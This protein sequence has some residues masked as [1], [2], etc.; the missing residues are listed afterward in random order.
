M[1]TFDMDRFHM[2]RLEPGSDLLGGIEDFLNDRGIRSGYFW[3]LGAV[4]KGAVGYYDQAS[5]EY[6]TIEFDS[7]ME[8]VVC[9]GNISVKLGKSAP[10]AHISLSDETGRTFGGH[11]QPGNEVFVAE[12]CV[13]EFTGRP[14]ER[15]TIPD[16]GLELWPTGQ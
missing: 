8:I 2:G 5:R 11:L 14:L 3:V 13:A 6:R 15:E 1:R 4:R 10:H 7:P 9:H 12:L 16:L